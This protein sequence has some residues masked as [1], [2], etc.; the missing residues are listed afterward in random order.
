MDPMQLS[1]ILI[2][3]ILLSGFIAHTLNM[4]RIYSRVKD[5]KVPNV[6]R[7]G[8]FNELL[9]PQGSNFNTLAIVAWMLL[10][11]AIA[12]FY[13]LT[14]AIFPNINY[15]TLAPEYATYWMGFA[16]FGL[17]IAGVIGLIIA[18]TIKLPDSLGCYRIGELYG[19]YTLDKNIKR[20]IA[21]TIIPLCLSIGITAAMG[22]VY[23][24]GWWVWMLL[25]FIF[26]SV[27]LIILLY[28]IFTEWLEGR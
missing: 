16:F 18:A 10:I 13:F 20:A 24:D 19:F 4:R 12:Y 5:L 22:T 3:V 23:P 2:L 6:T 1:F 14:P 11:V 25:A 9:V 21:I 8:L 15:F 7:D 27:S 17:F 28:P 26:L